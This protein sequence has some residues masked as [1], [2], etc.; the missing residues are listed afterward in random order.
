MIRGR[1]PAASLNEFDAYADDYDRQLQAGLS[2]TGET[3]D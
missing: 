2:L 1:P 3:K